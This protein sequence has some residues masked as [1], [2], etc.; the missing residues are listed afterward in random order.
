MLKHLSDNKKNADY[1]QTHYE[2]RH[3]Q[4][5]IFVSK[6]PI[7]FHINKRKC[8]LTQ[9]ISLRCVEYCISTVVWQ[10]GALQEKI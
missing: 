2:V 1:Q 3:G 5:D 7:I 6:S 4:D 10:G 9:I 8:I